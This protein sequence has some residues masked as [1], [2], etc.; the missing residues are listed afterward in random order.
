VA[1]PAA[2]RDVALSPACSPQYG[3]RQS[4]GKLLEAK[5]ALATFALCSRCSIPFDGA[6]LKNGET[7]WQVDS[8]QRNL[9]MIS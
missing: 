5:T 7:L 9:W 6:A 3:R 2:R 1:L 4:S 8:L